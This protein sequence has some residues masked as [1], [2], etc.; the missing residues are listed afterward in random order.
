MAIG[1]GIVSR[2]C[3]AGPDQKPLNPG[4][5]QKLADFTREYYKDNWSST[6]LKFLKF[7]NP[8]IANAQLLT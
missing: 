8:N 1:D 3:A 2:A 6:I 4:E 5:V 7:S